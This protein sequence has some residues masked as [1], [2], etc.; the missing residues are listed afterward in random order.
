LV[1]SNVRENPAQLFTDEATATKRG[2]TARLPDG[3]ENETG[4]KSSQMKID[5]SIPRHTQLI[6]KL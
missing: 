3:E 6:L 2:A 5:R 1:I 4:H